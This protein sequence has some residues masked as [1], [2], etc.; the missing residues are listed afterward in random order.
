M[1]TIK[2]FRRKYRLTQKELA[3]KIGIT[4]ATLSKYENGHWSINQAVI[5]RIKEE[6][7]EEIRPVQRRTGAKKGVGK[8]GLNYF[9]NGGRCGGITVLTIAIV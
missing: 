3:L 8:E 6:Y 7:G 2:Q 4:P 1:L 5:D 9:L